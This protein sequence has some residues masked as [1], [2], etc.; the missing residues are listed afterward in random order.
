MKQSF[1]LIAKY[2]APNNRRGSR[3]TLTNKPCNI[4]IT[5]SWDYSFGHSIHSQVK[6]FLKEYN[7]EIENWS[8]M[9]P[10]KNIIMISW[11]DYKL[12]ED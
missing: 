9:T 12:L 11:D 3:I 2:Q 1:H 7:I 10:E 6:E 5:F 8:E 4:R